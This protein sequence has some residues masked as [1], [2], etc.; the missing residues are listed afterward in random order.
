MK[1]LFQLVI[2]VFMFQS[3]AIG[4]QID[5]NIT[6][7]TYLNN[8]KL[9]DKLL[10]PK[11]GNII[12]LLETN[13]SV[14][15]NDIKLDKF[16]FI[17][18]THISDTLNLPAFA[19]GQQFTM[20]DGATIMQMWFNSDNGLIHGMVNKKQSING[21]TIIGILPKEFI[22]FKLAIS[23]NSFVSQEYIQK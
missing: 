11:E 12:V 7:V 21:T 22:S 4:Q 6:K 2:L 9:C 19:I 14:D 16:K 10:T 3:Y 17:C 20:A 5:V 8:Y 23:D 15:I 13:L 1:K 18:K